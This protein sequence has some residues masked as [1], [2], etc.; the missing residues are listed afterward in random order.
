MKTAIATKLLLALYLTL[1]CSC[2]FGQVV[3]KKSPSADEA[4]SRTKLQSTTVGETKNVHRLGD[5]FFA[6]QF[7]KED[8]EK[9]KD[10][11][12][13]RVITLR[14]DGEVDWDEQ[15]A[16]ESAGVEFMSVPFRPDSLTDDVFAK[17]RGLLRDESKKTLLHCGSANRVGGVWLTYRVLDEGVDLQTALAEAKEVG[18]RTPLIEAKAIDY[19]KRQQQ[20]ESGR[21]E[22]VKPDVNKKFVDPNLDVDSFVKRFE[23]ESREVFVN[24]ERILA[25][26]EIEKGDTVAD[27]GAGTGL[28]TRLFALEVG[29]EGWVYAVDI[30][31]RFIQH[32]NGEALKAKLNN[33]TGVLCAENSANL[34]PNSADIVF[35]C[36]TYHHF[37]YP[38]S[39]LASIK[40]ALKND[41]HL[42]LIDFD[43]VEGKSRDWLLQHVRAGKE[44]FRDEIQAA[45]F[46]LVEEKKID[47][48][49]ENYFLKFKKN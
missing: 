20:I 36:D 39:T 13:A 19:I 7:N 9:I 35:V 42:I 17:V 22:S 10:Q 4:G 48:F 33:I 5:L 44:V 40:R 25:A 12:I 24:R 23:I 41:G 16:V 8:I 2:T 28:F 6:G 11:N 38:K 15:A 26:C 43:R 1:S 29:N 49:E 27:I 46:S 34:P 21:E 14:T 18:L 37:E 47:G 45:G 31:P 3:E 30:A 32:I